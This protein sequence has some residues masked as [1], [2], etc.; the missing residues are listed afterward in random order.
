MDLKKIAGMVLRK[1]MVNRVSMEFDTDE[2]RKKYLNDHPA[3]DKSKHTVK[4]QEKPQRDMAQN[5]YNQ[6][7]ERDNAKK[8]KEI[9]DFYG[10][11]PKD[12]SVDEIT[13][14]NQGNAKK[15]AGDS[16]QNTQK[17]LSDGL[18][19]WVDDYKAARKSNPSLAKKIKQNIDKVIKDKGLDS[20]TVY[21]SGVSDPQDHPANNHPSTADASGLRE[22]GQTTAGFEKALKTHAKSDSPEALQA[23]AKEFESASR[24]RIKGLSAKIIRFLQGQGSSDISTNELNNM[25]KSSELPESV[26]AAAQ[27]L[28]DS[29]SATA[30][31]LRYS[32]EAQEAKKPVKVKTKVSPKAKPVLEKNDLYE[33]DTEIAEMAVFKKTLGERGNGR[34]PAQLKADFIKMMNP[35]SYD[36]PEAFKAAQERIKKMSPQD[37]DIVLSALSDDED[38]KTSSR[39]IAGMNDRVMM[40]RVAS[41][42]VRVAKLL[43]AAP[44]DSIIEGIQVNRLN[45]IQDSLTSFAPRLKVMM[46]KRAADDLGC[47]PNDLKREH[48]SYYTFLDHGG[49]RTGV[50]SNKYHYYVIFSRTNE[51]GETVYSSWN[52]SGKINNIERHYNLTLKG[53]KVPEVTE[54]PKAIRA[55]EAH[56]S[57]KVGKGYEE[58][59]YI[60]G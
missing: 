27:D 41:E 35:A 7:R 21:S 58:A 33:D 12:L 9:G 5:P 3:A 48:S 22:M 13:D 59:K 44:W 29:Y 17:A 37:F 18:S 4:K 40:R 20:D 38:V 26:R 60:R 19:K 28:Y 50:N 1:A 47:Q 43:Q 16:K 45:S 31:I 55:M 53:F 51:N 23:A 56:K 15:P 46:A 8:M 34:N 2:Q 11:D 36:S 14:F 52:C 42:L 25:A 32:Q 54:W 6:M 39:K 49:E 30:N 24:E 57:L 10:K